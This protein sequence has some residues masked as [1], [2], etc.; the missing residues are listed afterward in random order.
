[1]RN[2][3]RWLLTAGLAVLP[4]LALALI[5]HTTTVRAQGSVLWSADHEGPGEAKWY[6]PGGINFG[7]GELN[8]GC[9]GTTFTV[10]DNDPNT[11]NVHA[12]SRGRQLRARAEN[13]RALR[14]RNGFRH[15]VV[16]MEGAER[17]SRSVLQSLVLL[18]SKLP[19]G[20]ESRLRRFGTSLDGSP[21]RSIRRGTKCSGT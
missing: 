7:G 17:T 16:Q 8:S 3:S 2:R 5:R 4:L 19:P 6:H 18:S 11:P 21:R 13:D 15:E 14:Q 10:Y 20:R 12:S 1:M 9:A